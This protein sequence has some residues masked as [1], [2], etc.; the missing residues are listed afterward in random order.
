MTGRR[1]GRRRTAPPILLLLSALA[2]VGHGGQTFRTSNPLKAFVHGD[3]PWGDDYFIH[4]NGDTILFRCVLLEK[5]DGFDGV[6]LSE[7]S[8]WGNHGGP[9]EMFRKTGTKFEYVG[10]GEVRDTSCLES[11]RSKDYLASG[12][13]R[14]QRGWPD[15]PTATAAARS[16][17]LAIDTLSEAE[18]SAAPFECD[19]EFH[20]GDVDGRTVVFATRAHR[21]RAVARIDGTTRQ[22]RL[23]RKTDEGDCRKGRPHSE[24]WTDGSVSIDLDTTVTTSGDEA[25]W[26][27]GRMTVTK[28]E[29]RERIAVTG[30]CGC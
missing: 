16:R 22:M 18:L 6:A 4:G 7:V 10:P 5:R 15:A 12:R 25:C 13:C 30:S 23:V 2:G 26:Y 21:T 3:Y 8:I 19:C 29:R 14:W 1:S 27:L 17:P 9:W 20:R 28:G 11:C 24:R